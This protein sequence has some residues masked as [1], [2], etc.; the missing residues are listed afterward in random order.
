MNYNKWSAILRQFIYIHFVN[1]ERIKYLKYSH[2]SICPKYFRASSPTTPP[3]SILIHIEC[4]GAATVPDMQ[5]E[6]RSDDGRT[7]RKREVYRLASAAEGFGKVS[8][9]NNITLTSKRKSSSDINRTSESSHQRSGFTWTKMVC[10]C[11]AIPS[12]TYYP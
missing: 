3:H 12:V 6:P 10:C 5:T 8:Y 11:A 4:L 1:K 7:L 2:L 9:K